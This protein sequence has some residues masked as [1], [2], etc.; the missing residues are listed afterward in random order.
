MAN[1]IDPRG[2]TRLSDFIRQGHNGTMGN[3]F[4]QGY[5]GM[6]GKFIRQWHNGIFRRSFA[7]F[8]N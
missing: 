4:R 1:I 2:V 5:N 3:L 6:M 8:F 7:L